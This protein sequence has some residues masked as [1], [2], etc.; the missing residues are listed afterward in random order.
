MKMSLKYKIVG[1]SV[2][3]VVVFGTLYCHS[4]MQEIEN[5]KEIAGLTLQYIKQGRYVGEGEGT[6]PIIQ[7]ELIHENGSVKWKMLHAYYFNNGTITPMTNE[8]LKDYYVT[9]SMFYSDTPAYQ[10][11]KGWP[12]FVHFH[13]KELNW[14]GT[15]A[16]V[17]VGGSSGPTAGHGNEIYLTKMPFGEWEIESEGNYWIS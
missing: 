11:H 6:I 10:Y 12:Y 16:T 15:K 9:Y 14:F 1:I 5:K 2:I 17:A 7:Y 13:I 8:Q 4:P 3:L